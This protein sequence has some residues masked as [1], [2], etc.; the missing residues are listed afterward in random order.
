[1]LG[2][3]NRTKLSIASAGVGLV[4][5][6]GASV[7]AMGQGTEPDQASS[8]PPAPETVVETVTRVETVTETVTEE[9]ASAPVVVTEVLDVPGDGL[10]EAGIANR[11]TRSDLVGD[12][13]APSLTTQPET[14]EIPP[15]TTAPPTT[16]KPPVTS[17]PTTTPNLPPTT[18]TQPPVTTSD[19][20]PTTVSTGP[21]SD[22]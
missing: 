4:V 9:V 1:M 7:F 16:T 22:G 2:V 12:S 14:P 20:P 3:M 10:K 19:L 8:Y 5:L 21:S 18:T 6:G 13:P 11:E 17:E 15:T